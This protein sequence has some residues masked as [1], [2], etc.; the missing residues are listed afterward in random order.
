ML[1]LAL[2]GNHTLTEVSQTTADVHTLGYVRSNM[3]LGNL[4]V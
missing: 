1:C 3:T 2:K 4:A